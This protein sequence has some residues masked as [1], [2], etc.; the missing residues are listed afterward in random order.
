SS[1]LLFFIIMIH[2]IF[3][4]LYSYNLK[5]SNLH[6]WHYCMRLH[7][8]RQMG[9]F[10]FIGICGFISRIVL[11]HYISNAGGSVKAL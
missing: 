3:I 7:Q 5:E 6:K 8:V 9:H 4:H 1:Q 2:V 11:N 10:Y